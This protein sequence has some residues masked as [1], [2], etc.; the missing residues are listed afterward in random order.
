MDA[1]IAATPPA[2][3]PGDTSRTAAVSYHAM[4]R[5][6]PKVERLRRALELTALARDLAWEGAV[7]H[8]QSEG[9]AAIV[10]RF[11]RQFHGD[12]VARVFGPALAPSSG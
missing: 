1:S 11:L 10:Q 8:A 7:R 12:D 9:E 5:H 3:T 2:I 4:L 6:L